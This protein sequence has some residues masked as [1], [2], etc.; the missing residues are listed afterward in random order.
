MRMTRV[1]PRSL[2]LIYYVFA[3]A[4]HTDFSFRSAPRFYARVYLLNMYVQVL[5]YGNL[6]DWRVRVCIAR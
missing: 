5:A 4:L 1:H 3:V 2:C 6:M